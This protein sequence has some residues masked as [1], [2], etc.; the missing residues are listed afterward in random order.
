MRV[1]VTG[2][3]GQVGHALIGRAT[4]AG[5]DVAAHARAGLDIADADAVYA[6]VREARPDVVFNAAAYTAVD[7]AESEPDRAMAVNADGPA[8]LA[9]ACREV[10]ARLVHFSTDYVFDGLKRGAWVESDPVGPT[11]VYGRTKAAGEA[12]VR[13]ALPDALILR[14][15]WVFSAHGAN[16]VKTMVRLALERDAL[17]VVADQHGCPTYAGDIAD[18]ALAL[19]A[20]GVGGT[21]H[22]AGSPPTTWHGFATR[23][24]A[25]A[26]RRRPL[27]A[28]RVDAITTAD[29]PTPARR[30]ANSVLDCAAVE[31]LGIPAPPWENGLEA[32]LG[33]I[34]P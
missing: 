7:K 15:S 20:R 27:R 23:I 25:S 24:V 19:A 30:P 12:R 32:V 29:Y 13:D 10:G 6:R 1:L 33:E 14:T 17:R 3:D 21:L 16:F 9:A 5:H 2:A 11:S 26:G 31:A 4:A 34:L 28:Q 8:H 22:F 18:A